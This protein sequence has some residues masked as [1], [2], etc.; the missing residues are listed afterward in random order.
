M[1]LTL[2]DSCEGGVA[3]AFFAG[4][5]GVGAAEEEGAG[6]KMIACEEG[7]FG[8]AHLEGKG[9]VRETLSG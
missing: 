4:C 1:T 2:D 8:V 6:S 9:V 7:V 3:I 5:T